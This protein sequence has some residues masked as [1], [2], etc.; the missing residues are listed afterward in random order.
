MRGNGAQN[1]DG[2]ALRPDSPCG[3]TAH[4]DDGSP[5]E[6][7]LRRTGGPDGGEEVMAGRERGMAAGSSCLFLQ[8][9]LSSFLEWA[10]FHWVYF[11]ALGRWP[12]VWQSWLFQNLSVT[13]LHAI[14]L[15][16]LG[17]PC[18]A[19]CGQLES[20]RCV[21]VLRWVAGAPDLRWHHPGPRRVCWSVP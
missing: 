17:H 4:D 11:P 18:L 13:E 12:K 7:P 16:S 2:D 21:V 6:G 8:A 5:S 1:C 15:P 3:C 9:W 14:A 20:S 19:P 10:S